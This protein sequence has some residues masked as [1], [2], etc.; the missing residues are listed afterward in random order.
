MAPLMKTAAAVLRTGKWLLPALALV[1]FFSP[2]RAQEH[3][4]LGP[5]GG[6]ELQ[7]AAAATAA[8]D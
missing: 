3:P 2:A 7:Q 6:Q 4:Q 5:A 8:P 1:F